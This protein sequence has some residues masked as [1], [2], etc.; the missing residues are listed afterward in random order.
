MGYIE[1]EVSCLLTKPG[2]PRENLGHPLPKKQKKGR[3]HEQGQGKAE[4]ERKTI[5]EGL[6]ILD[7]SAE[8]RSIRLCDGGLN[9][10]EE[11]LFK[12][13]HVSLGWG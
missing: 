6:K 11:A 3:A 2:F 10:E 9:V 7:V 13:K 1:G 5:V 8:Q 12:H 4:R